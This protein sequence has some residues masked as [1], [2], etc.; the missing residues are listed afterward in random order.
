V[1]SE[2]R[3]HLLRAIIERKDETYP[4]P[5]LPPANPDD[6]YVWRGEEELEAVLA[7]ME[8]KDGSAQGGNHSRI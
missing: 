3:Y 6:F 7:E 4:L 2:Q 1:T 8:L 5:S